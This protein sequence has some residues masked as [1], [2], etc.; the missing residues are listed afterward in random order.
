MPGNAELV[1]EGSYGY[2]FSDSASSVTVSGCDST[3]RVPGCFYYRYLTTSPELGGV[4]S[5]RRAHEGGATLAMPVAVDVQ[6]I[7]VQAPPQMRVA[8]G[9]AHPPVSAV[10][11]ERPELPVIR[12]AV[13]SR[14]AIR[15]S[16]RGTMRHLDPWGVL[17]RGGLH[18]GGL[19]FE[20]PPLDG[21][22]PLGGVRAGAR[23][24]LACHEGSLARYLG[25]H[26]P[27]SA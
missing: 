1:F 18:V 21:A 16:Y 13:A 19:D 2:R 10:L 15:F 7:A 22:S 26:G 12:G 25:E 17:L 5:N 8:A 6:N 23:L 24:D 11:P 27:R 3:N 4:S 20:V 9:G 14:A